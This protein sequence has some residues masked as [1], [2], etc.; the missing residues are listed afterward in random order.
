[1]DYDK[2]K[3]WTTTAYLRSYKVLSDDVY[4]PWNSGHP[5]AP[6]LNGGVPGDS[7]LKTVL[8]ELTTSHEQQN[9]FVY[10]FQHHQ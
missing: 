1:L 2:G 8:S 7:A 10:Q 6:P 3:G 9:L 4:D 5:Q